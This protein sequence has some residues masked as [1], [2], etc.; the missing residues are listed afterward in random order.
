M[1][2]NL[3]YLDPEIPPTAAIEGVDLVTEGVITISKVLDYAKDYLRIMRP[4]RSGV[5]SGTAP[6]DLPHAV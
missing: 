1:V 3:D 6:P 2:A 4:T 5:T